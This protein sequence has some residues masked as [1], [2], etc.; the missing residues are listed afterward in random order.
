MEAFGSE[1]PNIGPFACAGDI[2]SMIQ[3][4]GSDMD[5]D[6]RE[7]AVRALGDLG[8]ARVVEPLIAM[9]GTSREVHIVWVRET[10]VRSLGQIGDAREIEPLIAILM[11]PSV[12]LRAAAA[13]AQGEIG[14]RRAADPLNAALRDPSHGVREAVA[15][16]LRT[17]V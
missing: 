8:D 17:M 6:I 14:D 7:V 13:R 3:M 5:P 11:D 1:I 10:T 4:A 16:A 9:L 2:D 15:G 12:S